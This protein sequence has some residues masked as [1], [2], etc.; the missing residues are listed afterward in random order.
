[1]KKYSYSISE[2]YSEKELNEKFDLITLYKNN[3]L[4]LIE[5]LKKYGIIS[6][7][8]SD[9]ITLKIRRN[10]NYASLP[11][12][13]SK[14]YDEHDLLVSKIKLSEEDQKILSF[15]GEI[16]ENLDFSKT[17]F[18]T[19]LNDNNYDNT[20]DEDVIC[21]LHFKGFEWNLEKLK[22]YKNMVEMT[23]LNEQAKTLGIN[24]NMDSKNNERLNKLLEQQKQKCIEKKELY[25]YK[26]KNTF[27]LYYN[28]PYIYD[29]KLQTFTED[30][31]EIIIERIND[32]LKLNMH[33]EEDR[34][35]MYV[36][37]SLRQYQINLKNRGFKK[38]KMIDDETL[39]IIENCVLS[40]NKDNKNM[41][42]K[43]KIVSDQPIVNSMEKENILLKK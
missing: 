9:Q 32:L 10:Y 31:I 27:V 20:I 15:E 26:T 30:E 28:A 29:S 18:N 24:N 22:N 40:N 43:L 1:M 17:D 19:F 4:G 34:F 33:S 3:K 14:Y 5:M 13:S 35:L 6:T 11:L 23:S 2:I 8:E 16:Y 37:A 42:L 38:E 25:I 36:V 41:F 12:V 7:L 21:C 39:K